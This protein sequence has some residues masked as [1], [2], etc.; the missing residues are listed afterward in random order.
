MLL[1]ASEEYQQYDDQ[2]CSGSVRTNWACACLGAKKKRS[3]RV[4]K[5]MAEKQGLSLGADFYSLVTVSCFAVREA[6]TCLPPVV[7]VQSARFVLSL[8]HISYCH[9]GVGPVHLFCSRPS[10]THTF[11]FL[12]H[13]FYL[14]FGQDLSRVYRVQIKQ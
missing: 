5:I 13:I 1:K 8:L 3:L 4:Q 2:R 12:T 10:I 14:R 6:A 9:A 11:H 7:L